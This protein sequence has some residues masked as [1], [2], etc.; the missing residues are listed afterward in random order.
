M[1]KFNTNLKIK[2]IR[3][4][5]NLIKGHYEKPTAN[6]CSGGK[7]ECSPFRWGTERMYMLSFLLRFVLKFLLS[8]LREINKAHIQEGSNKTIYADKQ[9]CLDRKS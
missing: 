3:I 2:L 6:T 1:T 8:A 7:L 4:K 5:V 9:G